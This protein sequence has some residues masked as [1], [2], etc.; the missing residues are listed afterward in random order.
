MGSTGDVDP[1]HFLELFLTPPITVS[2]AVLWLQQEA[3]RGI[4]LVMQVV[5]S[6]LPVVS[7]QLHVFSFSLKNDMVL[8][9]FI[10]FHL[11]FIAQ[12]WAPYCVQREGHLAERL[13]HS[14]VL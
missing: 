13:P 4:C 6:M 2:H 3:I 8:G 5:L 10:F 12:K 7:G 9:S 11:G 1:A 14:T